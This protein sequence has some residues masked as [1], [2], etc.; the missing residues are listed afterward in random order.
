M[1]KQL[2]ACIIYKNYSVF[3][4]CSPATNSRGWWWKTDER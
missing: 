2:E 3:Y 4:K 1:K